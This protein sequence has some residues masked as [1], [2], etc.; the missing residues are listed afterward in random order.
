MCALEWETRLDDYWR[1]C[2]Q[3]LLVGMKEIRKPFPDIPLLDWSVSNRASATL[4]IVCLPKVPYAC[5]RFCT[6]RE[7]QTTLEHSGCQ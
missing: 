4:L 2:R 6:K 7:K 3:Y 1:A 5:T